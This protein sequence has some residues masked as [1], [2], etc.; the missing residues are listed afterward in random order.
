MSIT[1]SKRLPLRVFWQLMN[2]SS[3]QDILII[4]GMSFGN[5]EE[6][7]SCCAENFSTLD[8][9]EVPEDYQEKIYNYM[10]RL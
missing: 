6:F 8:W 2:R 7:T 5:R 1:E 10:V 9:H 4:I 3:R